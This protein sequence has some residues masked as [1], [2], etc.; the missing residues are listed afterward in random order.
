MKHLCKG[1]IV[2]TM[3]AGFKRLSW[4]RDKAVQAQDFGHH[5]EVDPLRTW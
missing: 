5:S 3:D 2:L 1:N 4:I